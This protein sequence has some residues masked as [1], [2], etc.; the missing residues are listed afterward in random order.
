MVALK[1]QKNSEIVVDSGLQEFFFSSLEDIN[2]KSLR[3]VPVEAL[4]YTS[5]VLERMSET[6]Q[7]FVEQDG[8]YRDEVL[9]VKLLESGAKCLEVQK[10]V[11]RD[12]GDKSLLIC[13]MFASNSRIVGQ[14]Y[15]LGLG[16]TAYQRL[17]SLIPSFYET[18]SFFNH[19]SS[20]L[21]VIISMVSELSEGLGLNQQ[22]HENLLIR[23]ESKDSE[24]LLSLGIVS[25][26]KDS[27]Q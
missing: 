11:L 7:F 26:Q 22:P 19:F 13:G 1:K 3:P 8:R 18:R 20:Y 2:Q 27:K 6:H 12:I 15:Y 14:D 25:C 21:E 24:E 16:R 10:R 23:I 4:H 5:G 17:N 9:G